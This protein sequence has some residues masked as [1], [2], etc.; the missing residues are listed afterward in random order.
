VESIR[1]KLLAKRLRIT[2]EYALRLAK[3]YGFELHYG[4]RRAAYISVKDAEKLITEYRAKHPK[5][6]LISNQTDFDGFGLFYI[7][8]LLP[9]EIPDR[10]KIGYT[11]NL[12]QRLSD[13]RTS[14]PTLK[15]LKSWPC[16]RTWEHAVIASVTRA[17]C[18]NIG[19]EVYEGRAIG[20]VERA[21]KFFEL[22]P[23]PE[24]GNT[25]VNS[26][27]SQK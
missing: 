14:N 16:K 12:T 13:H 17:E 11:D 9:D 1:I 6:N 24:K 7:I 25:P 8:Q 21:E 27:I 19:G 15:L 10:I 22:M 4:K 3:K 2:N 5:K 18:I 23:Q 20:F 26:N